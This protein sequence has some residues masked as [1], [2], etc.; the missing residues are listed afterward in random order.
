MFCPNCSATCLAEDGSCHNCHRPLPT[1]PRQSTVVSWSCG[2]SA[3][4]AVLLVVV[5]A[6]LSSGGGIAAALCV[7]VPFAFGAACVGGLMGWVIGRL[8]CAH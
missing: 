3:L 6:P 4:L 5:A 8:V 1:G 7:A 2:I